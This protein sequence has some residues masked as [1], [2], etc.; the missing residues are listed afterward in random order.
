MSDDQDRQRERLRPTR[1]VVGVTIPLLGL[2]ILLTMVLAFE[3]WQA[4]RR[5]RASV[6]GVLRDY[7]QAAAAHIV[8]ETWTAMGIV[9]TA[10]RPLSG[11]HLEHG[12]PLPPLAPLRV[13]TEQLARCAVPAADPDRYYFR[14]DFRTGGVEMTG[15]RPPP[16]DLALLADTVRHRVTTTR[17]EEWYL[18]PMFRVLPSGP[19]ALIYVVV[20]DRDEAPVAAYGFETCN[21]AIWEQVFRRVMAV[22]V[23][24]M[25]VAGGLPNDSLVSVTV[26]ASGQFSGSFQSP[27]HYPPTYSAD[28]V[29]QEETR[30][31]IRVQLALRPSLADRIVLG[32]VPRSHLPILL[33]CLGLT[34]GVLAIVLRQLARE[35]ELAR[36]RSEFATSVS[37]ELRTPLAE[38]LL[39]AETLELNRVTDGAGRSEAIRIIAQEA[40]HLSYIV[41]NVLQFSRAER[42][43]LRIESERIALGPALRDA[44]T[45]FGALAAS[46]Q[47]A[48][49][50]QVAD[51]IVAPVHRGS[52]HQIVLNLLDN[53]VKYGPTGQ[54]ITLRSRCIN[55]MARIE[56]DDQGPG[57]PARDRKRVW[58]P[59]VR[60]A[61]RR[62]APGGNGIG[63]AVVREL[64]AAHRG[65]CWIEASPG[66]GT[67]VVVEL[68]GAIQDAA[69]AGSYPLLDITR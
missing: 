21:A 53:A 69:I 27:V 22:P 68:P 60:L 38:I 64:V 28:V 58:D 46:S 5:H 15:P 47:A 63:L 54:A 17:Q 56:V 8:S 29:D 18:A 55:G 40:R 26:T 11:Y 49:G 41:E 3:A 24:P 62:G 25:T 50:L 37:H 67:R 6:E 32:G 14:F 35:R 42:R 33:A 45:S 66:G 9:T 57:I 39:F 16:S 12:A 1:S 52:L 51:D 59:Y 13:S 30:G 4:E 20:R 44:A 31:S 2:V 36:R 7:A 61:G 65:R 19:R 48:L 34:I 43:M 23:L 10:F